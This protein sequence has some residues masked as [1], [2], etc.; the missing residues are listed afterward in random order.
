ME[1]WDR[2]LHFF[3]Y[4]SELLC[5]GARNRRCGPLPSPAHICSDGLLNIGPA[6][7]GARNAVIRLLS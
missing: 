3:S 1:E 4:V 2:P 5:A 6:V 7:S